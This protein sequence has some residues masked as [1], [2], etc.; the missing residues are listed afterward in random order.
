MVYRNREVIRESLHIRIED[1][2]QAQALG[3]ECEVDRRH[4]APRKWFIP[5]SLPIE[6]PEDAATLRRIWGPK[7]ARSLARTLGAG[8]TT[9]CGWSSK[10]AAPFEPPKRVA[11]VNQ[12]VSDA[13]A[14]AVPDD[15]KTHSTGTQTTTAS[16]EPTQ[17]VQKE[18]YC[19]ITQ[20]IMEDPVLASDGHTYEREAIET[21]HQINNTS[22]ITRLRNTALI[23]NRALKS[24]ID[25]QRLTWAS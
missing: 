19:P 20:E 5:N 2:D 25:K 4:G 17:E 21:W 14:N 15:K 1:E 7:V 12:L 9:R 22:P 18:F 16:P 13:S 11:S 6:R 24:V 3:A 10:A 23:P 8:G